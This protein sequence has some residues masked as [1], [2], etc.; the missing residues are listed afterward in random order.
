MHEDKATVEKTSLQNDRTDGSTLQL[1][2]LEDGFHR[3]AIIGYRQ[4]HER[5]G[6]LN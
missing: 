5:P 3:N 6:I 1:N 2:L 4:F